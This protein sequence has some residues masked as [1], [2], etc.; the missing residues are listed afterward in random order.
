MEEVKEQTGPM[1]EEVTCDP[2]EGLSAQ[3]VMGSEPVG[4]EER[5]QEGRGG[6]ACPTFI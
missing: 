1:Q 4:G 5:V 2:C 3:G 6:C